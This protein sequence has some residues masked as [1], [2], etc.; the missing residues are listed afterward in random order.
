MTYNV[1]YKI[2]NRFW[3]KVNKG[4]EDQCWVWNAGCNPKGYGNFW[5]NGK[6]VTASCYAYTL[7][8]GTITPHMNVLHSCDNPPCCN[9]K[10]LFLG[11]HKDNAVDREHKHRC[12]RDKGDD[13]TN[14]KLTWH[15][16][17][18]I[19]NKHAFG[20]LSQTELART[21]NVSVQLINKIVHNKV[22]KN[23]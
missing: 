8:Y 1:S 3:S 6:T 15:D 22:W 12:N 14:A 23:D 10:H 20:E 2:H 19:R 13:H 17:D 7:T 11:T 18:I 9:P 5:V 21:F 4:D 16:I